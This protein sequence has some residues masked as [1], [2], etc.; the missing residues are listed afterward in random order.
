MT[1]RR[2]GKAVATVEPTFLVEGHEATLNGDHMRI[3]EDAEGR[4]T[5]EFSPKSLTGRVCGGC[6]LC[7]KLVPVPTIDKPA[8]QRCRH[9]RHGKGCAIYAARPFACRTWSC[10]WLSD[11]STAGLPRPD[12]AHYVIDMQA[13]D[14]RLVSPDG[15]PIHLSAFQVWV[16]PAFPEAWRSPELLAWISHMAEV[17]R[18]PTIIRWGSERGLTVF[19]PPLNAANEWVEM[20]GQCVPQNELQAHL[21]A[22]RVAAQGGQP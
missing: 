17:R 7:C 16:D 10:R 8:S 14:I 1:R 12:R 2:K 22:D 5:V 15:A 19:A 3:T 9:Q 13:E 21:A 11:E 20:E 4:T 6:S 18:C